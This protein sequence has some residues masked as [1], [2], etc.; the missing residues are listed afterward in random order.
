MSAHE[1]DADAA[2]GALHRVEELINTFSVE[3]GT[4]SLTDPAALTTWLAER[5]LL[6]KTATATETDLHRARTL[7]EGLRA[8]L[9]AQNTP[10]ADAP[11]ED[12]APSPALTDLAA[13]ARELPVTLD[14]LAT[15]PALVPHSPGTP[16]AALAQLLADVARSAADGT[17]TRMKACRMCHWAYYDHSRNR[18]RAWCSMALCGNRAKA[19]AFRNR[20][21]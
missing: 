13:L 1:P 16:D 12:A 21:R 2:P 20:T 19:Q 8:L 6:P 11:S 3:T 18:S 4:E 7:R 5:G 15:P 10:P 14:P 9:V 17:W